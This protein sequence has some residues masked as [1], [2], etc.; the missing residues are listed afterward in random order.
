[1]LRE[2]LMRLVPPGVPS[3]TF[4]SPPVQVSPVDPV[5]IINQDPGDEHKEPPFCACS[6]CDPREE[7]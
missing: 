2:P 5:A 3:H 7:E 4:G 1:M 6:K